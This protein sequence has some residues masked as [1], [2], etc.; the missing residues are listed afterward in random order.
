MP[1]NSRRLQDAVNFI[2]I[3]SL[4]ARG[5]TEAEKNFGRQAHGP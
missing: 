5:E 2:E 3:C 4:I 1:Q